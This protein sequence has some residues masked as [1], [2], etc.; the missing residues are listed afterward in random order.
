MSLHPEEI[1]ERIDSYE[2]M[3]S[4][5]ISECEDLLSESKTLSEKISSIMNDSV[6]QNFFKIYNLIK[7]FSDT[8]NTDIMKLIC[9]SGLSEAR[10]SQQC[11]CLLWA[12]VQGNYFLV[13]D[14]IENGCNRDAIEI[15]GNNAL[16]DASGS[17]NISIVKYLIS[18][19]FD[20]N[21]R[22][23]KNG[24]SAIHLASQYG[25]LDV[26]KYLVQIGCD[27]NSKTKT[28]Y[29][30]C[31]ICAAVCGNLEL[32]KFLQSNGCDIKC[33][34]I[35]DD[36]CVHF[37]AA[38]NKPNIIEYLLGQDFDINVPGKNLNTSLHYAVENCGIETVKFLIKH[39][40]KLSEKNKENQTPLDIAKS[41]VETD[42]KFEEIIDILIN[43]RAS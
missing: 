5:C 39:G 1:R 36:L 23:S 24:N 21:W 9:K 38:K 8:N 33:K 18:E 3:I 43:A 22:N 26:V 41:K 13:Q 11:T 17:G 27:V 31:S 30:N 7:R 42:K 19:G 34:N 12:C 14:L 35:N 32:F 4:E 20:K 15:Y 28:V 16:L 25:H 37:A 10:E 40:A 2:K 29:S 6:N